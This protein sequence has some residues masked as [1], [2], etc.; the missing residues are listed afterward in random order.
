MAEGR[1]VPHLEEIVWKQG[2]LLSE[3]HPEQE[4]HRAQV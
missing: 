2:K 3:G 1:V 4:N